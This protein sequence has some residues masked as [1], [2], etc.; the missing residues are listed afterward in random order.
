MID[1]LEK[2]VG[3]R[4][5]INLHVKGNVYIYSV[6]I[7]QKNGIL[8]QLA[9]GTTPVPISFTEQDVR[10]VVIQNGLTVVTL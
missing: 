9:N 2:S 8:Y 6:G 5:L 4:I 1:E 10:N 3:N 7:L